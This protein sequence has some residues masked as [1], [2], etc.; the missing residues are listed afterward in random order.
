MPRV[1][2]QQQPF[3]ILAFRGCGF[4]NITGI[5][6]T[7]VVEVA[8]G[9]IARELQAVGRCA[10]KVEVLTAARGYHRR[11]E[12]ARHAFVLQP[13]RGLHVH[14]GV[15]AVRNTL[16]KNGVRVTLRICGIE[17]ILFS[18]YETVGQLVKIAVAA[19]KL[20]TGLVRIGVAR[21]AC[22]CSS[23][24]E[25]TIGVIKREIRHVTIALEQSEV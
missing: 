22:V 7:A 14:D 19:R 12:H 6:V 16:Q 15:T 23:G 5:L 8:C 18:C 24:N 1:A 2:A 11:G 25:V 13:R 9:G 3:G 17:G 10:C 4:I 20:C 21:P